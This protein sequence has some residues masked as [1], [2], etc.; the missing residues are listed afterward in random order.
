MS[1]IRNYF[2]TLDDPRSND[3]NVDHRLGDI[4]TIALCAVI[5][6]AEGWEDI[7]TFGLCRNSWFEEK[8]ELHEGIPSDDTFRRVGSG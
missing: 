1:N 5:G 2:D 8:L 3:W 4:L 6:G 7:E